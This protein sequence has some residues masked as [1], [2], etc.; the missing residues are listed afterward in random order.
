MDID[1]PINSKAVI[2][3]ACILVG[4]ANAIPSNDLRA[5]QRKKLGELADFE[6]FRVTQIDWTNKKEE[7]LIA[8]I[9]EKT[10]MDSTFEDGLAELGKKAITEYYKEAKKE[11]QVHTVP[12]AALFSHYLV[13]TMPKTAALPQVSQDG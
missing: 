8:K 9:Y 4:K 3:R 1:I 10:W 13:H 5:L 11:A 12:C 2:L 6:K 7:D